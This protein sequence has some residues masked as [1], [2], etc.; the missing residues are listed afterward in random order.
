MHPVTVHLPIGLLLA[1]SLLDALVALG[2]RPQW[3]D[4]AQMALIGGLLAAGLA[5]CAGF[6]DFLAIPAGAK[7]ERTAILHIAFIMVA[8]ALYGGALAWRM[9][10]P[11]GP[12]V[13]ALLS[14]AG[15][16]VLM[17]AGWFG[18]QLVY[19]FGQG[20]RTKEETS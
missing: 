13:A 14:A 5:V 16:L 10:G 8:L 17:L 20:V 15:G 2:G 6:V 19:H 4:F 12:G 9:V 3:A 18:G 1:A 7:V 11:A